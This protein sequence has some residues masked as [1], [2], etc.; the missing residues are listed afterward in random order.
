VSPPPRLAPTGI[1]TALFGR[2]RYPQLFS[3]LLV[4]LALDLVI[5]DVIPFLDELLLA[6][7]TLLVGSLRDRTPA[8]DKP[9][10]RNVTPR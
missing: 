7:A 5:P 6:A 3:V 4:L 2:L 9:P 10:E 8:V 1:L